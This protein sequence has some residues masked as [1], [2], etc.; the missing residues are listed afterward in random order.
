MQS[1]ANNVTVDSAIPTVATGHQSVKRDGM[2]VNYKS[3]VATPAS[4]LLWR[5]TF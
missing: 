1:L 5:D 3:D 4:W 2:R